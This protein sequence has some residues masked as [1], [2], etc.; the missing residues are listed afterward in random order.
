MGIQDNMTDEQKL[1]Y[2][3]KNPLCIFCKHSYTAFFK[4]W[5]KEYDIH[6]MPKAKECPCYCPTLVSID[7]RSPK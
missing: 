2:R 6:K 5:C 7:D 4:T 1:E 3:K